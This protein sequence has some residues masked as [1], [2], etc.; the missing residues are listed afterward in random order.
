MNLTVVGAGYIGLVTSLCF[1]EVGYNVFCV[2]VDQNKIQNLKKGISN[3]YEPQLERILHSNISSQKIHFFDNLKATEAHSSLYFIT[4]GTPLNSNNEADLTQVFSTVEQIALL[5]NPKKLVVIKSTVPPG[6]LQLLKEKYKNKDIEFVSNPEFIREGS[7]FSDCMNPDRI[8]IGTDSKSATQTLFEVYK[9]FVKN[10]KS[11]IY[12]DPASAELTKYAAN[13]MLASKISLMNEFSR[14]CEKTGANIDSVEIGIASD[15]RIGPHFLKAGLGYGGSCFPKDIHSFITLGK[16]LNEDLLVSKAVAQTNDFQIERFAK[17][18]IDHV[19]KPQKV[20]LWGAS[21]KPE[22]NDTREAPAIKI[23]QKLLEQ[24]FEVNIYDP[25][26]NQSISHCFEKHPQFKS[27]HFF[28][29]QYEALTNCQYLVICTE[30]KQFASADLEKMKS[31]SS[32]LHIFDGRNIFS[33][34]DLKKKN[35]SYYSIGR[36]Q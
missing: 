10:P 20:T 18:I 14:I 17:K 16:Q 23:I 13:I 19:Q 1:S 31:K 15:Q 8:I 35:I 7:A 29:D 36:P 22:T 34:E 28:N 3:I 21:F 9:P 26:A 2:D 6:T 33:L 5:N 32:Q 24:K 4:V 27:L 30:W 11:I 25:A 12:M